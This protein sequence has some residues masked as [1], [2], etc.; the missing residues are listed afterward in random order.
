MWMLGG[1]YG[2]GTHAFSG[3][4]SAVE[5]AM[6]TGLNSV[7]GQSRLLLGRVGLARARRTAPSAPRAT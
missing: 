1:D 5:S 3:G 4:E 6:I 7:A 2:T